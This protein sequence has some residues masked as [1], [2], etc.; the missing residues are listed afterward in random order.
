M[1]QR[2]LEAKVAPQWCSFK[3]LISLKILL[4]RFS[5]IVNLF[6]AFNLTSIKKKKKSLEVM[7]LHETIILSG[8]TQYLNSDE[9]I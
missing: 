9:V 8:Q 6:V 3:L 5:S 2:M 4:N 1:E 7:H